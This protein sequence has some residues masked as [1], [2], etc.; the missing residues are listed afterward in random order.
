MWF[1]S[2]GRGVLR[3]IIICCGLVGLSLAA[4]A[5][6]IDWNTRPATN[7]RGGATD[8]PTYGSA[9][10]LLT[11]TSSGSVAGTYD[12]AGPNTLA[13]EPA[14]TSNGTTGYVN[15]TMNAAVDDES[16][17]QTTTINFNEP[18][19]NAS[20]IVGDID[21]GP[22]FNISGA[23]FND[24]V[25]FRATNIAGSTILP[26][27]G[28]PQN[29]AI[30]T[31]NAATGR[32]LST[33]QN[34]TDNAGNVT[35]SFSG[36]IRTLT[37]RH[38]SGA[39]STVTNPS[40]QFIYIETVT[41]TRSPQL[42]LQKTSNGGVGTFNFDV[43]N[44]LNLA[45]SPWSSQTLS[46]SVTTAT[47]GTAVTGAYTRLYAT[48]TNTTIAETGAAG[49]LIT[50]TPATCTDANSA[51]S[52]NPASFT[53]AVS[54]YTVTL[55]AANV[56]AGAMITCSIING[57]RPT[58]QVR[59][60][61]VGNT[62]SFDF[63]GSNGFGTVTLNT[64]SVNP[65]PSAVMTLTT[66]ATATTVTE[67]IPSGW[68]LASATCTGMA[69]GGTAS[70]SGNILTLN[71]AATAATANIIC[72]FTNNKTPV[73]RVQKVTTGNFGGPFTFSSSNL[74]TTPGAIS[75]LA[76]N[77][78]TPAAPTANLV[79]TTGSP[80]TLGETF[81]LAWISAGVSCTDSNASVTGNPTPVATSATASVT[82]LGANVVN[83]A[84]IT[85]VFTNAA[86]AP[87][88]AVNKTASPTNVTAAGQIISFT[89]VVSNPGNV[90]LTSVTLTD[91]LGAVTCV[92]SGTN[93]IASLAVGANATCTVSYTATQADFDTN[94]GGDSDIDNTATAA[95]TYNSNPVSS[96]GSV[97]VAMT[98]NPQ[99]VIDKIGSPLAN[100]GVGGTITYTYRVRNAGNQTVTGVSVSDAHNGY[101]TAPVPG[102]E[103]M[104]VDAAPLSDSSDAAT[105]GVWDTLRPGDEIRFT[106]TYVVKQKDINLRQ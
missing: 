91:P 48:A 105:N 4:Y 19:Y 50:T 49:W 75:T 65:A 57:K 36:P 72:T 17:V 87:Q 102:N 20:V 53:A 26:T 35:V 61:S 51:V 59:K 104:L 28:T 34:V 95:S 62:G 74:A 25:E 8:S 103:I 58:L 13:I 9:P 46:T 43:G 67:T 81:S 101:G 96:Q 93:V 45:T 16:A 24:I 73:V 86:A 79:S 37:I 27:S 14:S 80:V 84:D 63:S 55:A 41:F 85:C 52:G 6:T 42:R 69:V 33:N 5:D 38:I 100:V 56:R 40:Q 12:S 97:A 10:T 98:L 99:L 23:A 60:L 90:P 32:A 71:A 7:L 11:V 39:N 47:A 89:M 76:V 15:S 106:A 77:S 83:G 3:I 68:T 66:A 64:A 92:P 88:L 82:I 22:T 94:G 1:P 31:W 54:G 44:V 30:V 18:V 78:G 2:V 29:A 70:L 21:G